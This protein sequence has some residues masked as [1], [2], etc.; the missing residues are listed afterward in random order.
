[1]EEGSINYAQVVIVESD[2]GDNV[3]ENTNSGDNADKNYDNR[4]IWK[5]RF[6]TFT[7]MLITK[8]IENFI[9]VA[10]SIAVILAFSIPDPGQITADVST[11]DLK[12]IVAFVNTVIVFFIS[13][14]TLKIEDLKGFSEYRNVVL[15]GLS[16]INFLT[17][18][19]AFIMLQ[20]PFATPEYS[21]G[22]TIFS[23]VPTTLGVG[24]ALTQAAKG[25]TMLS[26][27]LTV[28]SN[29]L[30]VVTV[31]Y[32]LSIYINNSDT[33]SVNID[34]KILAFYMLETVLA[35]S[36]LGIVV[37]RYSQSIKKLT[38][39][40]KQEL[41]CFSIANLMMIV[42]MT[43]SKSRSLIF[44]QNPGEIII[45][46]LTASIQHLFYLLIHWL[47]L[48]KL[49]CDRISKQQ[50]I[51]LI[52]MASQK[53]SPVALSVITVIASGTKR[54]LLTIPC[55]LGQLSQIFIGSILAPRLAKWVE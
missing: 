36:I 5:R 22:L 25:D 23:T 52:I 21:I 34:P 10:L 16:S 3:D 44:Q 30:G 38:T 33:S 53:S 37:R 19:L 11:P 55:I 48:T 50:S 8:A 54:G 40:Y 12:S 46:F 42:W 45:V 17:T 32:L 51:S 24:V 1:M 15:F 18:L 29:L 41:S 14:L 49:C 47:I 35:P 2:S 13:G 43:L 28:I 20:L 9:I 31:P 6:E 39:L 26:L 27:L 7:H 4:T